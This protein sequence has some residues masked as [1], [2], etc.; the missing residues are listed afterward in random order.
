MQLVSQG[1]A[2]KTL[3]NERKSSELYRALSDYS[4]TNQIDKIE[5]DLAIIKLEFANKLAF[6]SHDAP[7]FLPLPVTR[8]QSAKEENLIN[9]IE[10]EFLSMFDSLRH[11]R[12]SEKSNCNT[13]IS[14]CGFPTGGS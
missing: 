12:A 1:E 14:F 5:K 4:L 9:G 7:F 13:E 3:M 11:S 8:Q 2:L 6:A 10:N